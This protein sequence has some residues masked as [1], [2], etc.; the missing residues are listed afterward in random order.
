MLMYVDALGVQMG[1]EG[2][3]N[4]GVIVDFWVVYLDCMCLWVIFAR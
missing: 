4:G 2:E 1:E 3:E